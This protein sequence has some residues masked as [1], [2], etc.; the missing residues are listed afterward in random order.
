MALD[1]VMYMSSPE[2][3]IKLIMAV[4]EC[5]LSYPILDVGSHGLDNDVY[6]R[7][8]EISHICRPQWPTQ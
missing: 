2:D 3:D 1:R 4:G 7:S 6:S 8:Y 5:T